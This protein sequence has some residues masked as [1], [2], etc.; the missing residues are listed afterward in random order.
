MPVRKVTV[1]IKQ[2]LL[3]TPGQVSVLRG[4]QGQARFVWNQ[5]LHLRK[6]NAIMPREMSTMLAVL[7]E[8]H[9]WLKA[10]P[11]AVQQQAFRELQEAYARH[12][13]NPTHFGAPSF[14][15]RGHTTG[16]YLRDLKLRRV[17]RKYGETFVPKLGWVRFRITRLWAEITRAKSGRITVTPGG[18]WQV[19]FTVPDR[20][21]FTRT[22]TGHHIGIDLGGVV[23]ATSFDGVDTRYQN[24]PGL[25]P[26][27]QARYL[28][29]QRK[30][31]Q[32]TRGSGRNRKTK[33]QMGRITDR[34]VNRRRDWV[35][36]ITTEL[37]RKFDTI[38]I[39]DLNPKAMARRPHKVPDLENP[40]QFL[41]NRAA[42][43]AGLNKLI[44]ASS[45]GLI[46]ERLTDK[47]SRAGV[48]LIL[49]NPKHTSQRCAEC[50][51]IAKENRESQAVFRCVSCDHT[52]NA[53]RNA[54]RNI[55]AKGLLS[56]EEYAAGH[57]VKGR[58]LKQVNVNSTEPP[59]QSSE[60]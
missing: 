41:P 3:P 44:Y 19:S 51:H 30:L 17:N 60:R 56:P 32:Q 9:D 21:P 36:Q 31:E 52:D 25:R 1:S 4:Y 45:W 35:E 33:Q 37:V 50:G 39:E 14:K 55:L 46:R 54:A 47:A 40:G 22:P 48:R 10:G 38:V 53:D 11:S 27:E 49:V 43:K 24:I 34:L 26:H 5:M 23:T 57:A 6:T 2:R 16:V 15:K 20:P 18:A 28:R 42:A 59:E 58:T 29:L 8:Q 12:F 13:A 7:R